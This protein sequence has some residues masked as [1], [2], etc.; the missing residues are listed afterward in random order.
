[1]SQD[2]RLLEN[3]QGSELEAV[4]HE[5]CSNKKVWWVSDKWC[6][7]NGYDYFVKEAKIACVPLIAGKQEPYVKTP[8]YEL[9]PQLTTLAHKKFGPNLSRINIQK[10]KPE[11]CYDIHTDNGDYFLTTVR[12][13]LALNQEYFFKVAD[14]T[15]KI[16]VGDL[17]WFNNKKPHGAFNESAND[18]IAVIIDVQKEK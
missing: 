12:Y 11:S 10:I 13:S 3:L 2:F 4:Q 6:L 16:S 14:Q 1:M 17:F 8:F 15:V 9:F 5:V 18:R 7:D